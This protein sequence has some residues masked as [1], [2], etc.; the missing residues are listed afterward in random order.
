L[1]LGAY[2]AFIAGPLLLTDYLIHRSR[3][4]LLE[5]APPAAIGA[6]VVAAL[7]QVELMQGSREKLG[8]LAAQLRTSL[9][10]IHALQLSESKTPVLCARTVTSR[11]AARL[12][13]ALFQRGYHVEVLERLQPR[14]ESGV[15]RMLV[16][17]NHC[18]EH[19][20][21]LAEALRELTLRVD[22]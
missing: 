12:G 4:F 3:T 2:G 19:L 14:S 8:F 17:L 9:A 6:A 5:A 7:D 18:E 1:A 13:E 20:S 15:I 11:A 10:G 16:S 21:G 22:E